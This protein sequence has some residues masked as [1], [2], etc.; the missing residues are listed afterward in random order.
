MMLQN[1]RN[2]G[3]LD[4][5]SNEAAFATFTSDDILFASLIGRTG[6]ADDLNDL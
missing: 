4:I 1:L 3:M 2:K 6:Y 5:P